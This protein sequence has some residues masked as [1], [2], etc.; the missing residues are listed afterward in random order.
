MRN[1][2][3]KPSASCIETQFGRSACRRSGGEVDCSVLNSVAANRRPTP[4]LMGTDLPQHRH[5]QWIIVIVRAQT[6]QFTFCCGRDDPR[7]AGTAFE[8]FPTALRRVLAPHPASNSVCQSRAFIVLLAS[9]QVVTLWAL[10]LEA[11]CSKL[12]HRCRALAPQRAKAVSWLHPSPRP[13]L[14]CMHTPQITRPSAESVPLWRERRHHQSSPS[15]L[16]PVTRLT[17][18]AHLEQQPAAS[19]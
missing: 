14:F 10:S 19:Q 12:R 16:G 3:I 2:A 18:W 4:R 1:N 5:I 6:S 11:N 9:L 15:V 8:P 13:A 17:Q 7:K